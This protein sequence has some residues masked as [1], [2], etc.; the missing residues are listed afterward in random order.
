[1]EQQKTEFRIYEFPALEG[2]EFP[3]TGFYVWVDGKR[4]KKYNSS[5]DGKIWR[6]IIPQLLTTSIVEVRTKA[7]DKVVHIKRVGIEKKDRQDERDQVDQRT[8]VQG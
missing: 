8:A 2:F 1:M 6:I 5:F 7:E 4:T 3:K